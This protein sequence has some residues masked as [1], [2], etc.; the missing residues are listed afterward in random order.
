MNTHKGLFKYNRLTLGISS[1]PAVFQKMIESL[2]QGIAVVCVYIDAILVTG[3]SEE[4]HLWRLDKVLH[5]LD[6]AGICLKKEKCRFR[7]PDV[8]YLG[9]C[10]TCQGL[11]P[12]QEKVRAIREAPTPKKVEEL[13]AFFDL[14]KYPNLSSIL[15]P[16]YKLYGAEW[17][18]SSEQEAAVKQVKKM[19]DS[20]KLLDHY[21]RSKPLQLSCDV[22][23]P[24]VGAVLTQNLP[25]GQQK[26]LAFA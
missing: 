15:S 3:S 19:L 7:V 10:I 16:L 13:R 9:N 22:S 4:E 18:W 1:A 2:L 26:P 12:S 24:G 14:I 23:P 25:E 11:Q 8:E 21:D 6:E 17:K 20:T 5:R